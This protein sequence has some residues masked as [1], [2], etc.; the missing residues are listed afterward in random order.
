MKTLSVA[1]LLVVSSVA[2]FI[3]TTAY[4]GETS[5]PPK[6]AETCNSYTYSVLDSVNLFRR[7]VDPEVLSKMV[8]NMCETGYYDSKTNPQTIINRFQRLLGIRQKYMNQGNPTAVQ[9]A[10]AEYAMYKNGLL[11]GG[12]TFESLASFENAAGQA[13][14]IAVTENGAAPAAPAAP[15]STEQSNGAEVKGTYTCD[16]VFT[17]NGKVTGKEPGYVEVT[18]YGNYFSYDA[19]HGNRG[20]S[21]GNNANDINGGNGEAN[22]AYFLTPADASKKEN[23]VYSKTVMVNM[24]D[25]TT[26][27][28][29][30]AIRSDD[31]HIEFYATDVTDHF[32]MNM[33]NCK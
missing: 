25:N 8:N 11:F 13:G 4:A 26:H 5:L 29:V 21:T 24:S 23:G 19:P 28:M 33:V 3:S 10:D 14:P 1:A 16:V 22:P 17:N 2:A 20:D 18:L 30:Y 12:V 7:V 31:K 6:I 27:K 15:A 32:G 9:I